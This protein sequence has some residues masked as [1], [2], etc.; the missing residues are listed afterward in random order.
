MYMICAV[1]VL[2]GAISL[3]RLPVDLMPD[4]TY[5]S[6]TIRVSYAGVGPLEME[7]LVTRPVEQAVAAWRASCRST[8]RRRGE[9]D[10]AAEF[11]LGTNLN[12]ATDDV[13]S[14]IDRIRGRLPEDAD[15][16]ILF[17]FDARPCRS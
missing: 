5:P 11:R 17:K 4:V 12:A 7:E 8:P 15:A 3:V 16:P 6:I 1:I 9:F 13:R 2:L 14:R 10:G